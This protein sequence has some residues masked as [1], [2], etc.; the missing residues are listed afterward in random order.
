MSARQAFAHWR[1]S[2][3]QRRSDRR[4]RKVERLAAKDAAIRGGR[5]NEVDYAG[6][7]RRIDTPP[8]PLRRGLMALGV[9]GCRRDRSVG[10]G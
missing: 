9:W 3:Q 10:Q 5:M 2:R 1:E 4:A 6:S 8:K 7:D